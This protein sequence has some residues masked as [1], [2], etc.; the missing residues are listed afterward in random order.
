ML[1]LCSLM[2]ADDAMFWQA[3]CHPD[4]RVSAYNVDRQLNIGLAFKATSW[5]AS[6]YKAAA[7]HRYEHRR[8]TS[9]L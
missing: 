3:R 4:E 8:S 1:P 5:S 2:Y 7:C 6:E 9:A